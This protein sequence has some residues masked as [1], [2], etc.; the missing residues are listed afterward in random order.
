MAAI[1]VTS[2]LQLLL[3]ARSIT[4]VADGTALSAWPDDSPDGND[5]AQGTAGNRPVYKTNIFG[6]NPAVRTVDS[7]D[8]LHG[9]FASWGAHA[10]MTVLLCASNLPASGAQTA[11]GRFFTTAAAGQTDTANMLLG[12]VAASMQLWVNGSNRLPIALNMASAG[13]TQPV[14]FGGAYSSSVIDMIINGI[15]RGNHSYAGGLPS[16]PT[17]YSMGYINVGTPSTGFSCLADYHFIVVYNRRLTGS[18]LEQV[19]CWMRE[20][21]GMQPA[22]SGG[23]G[24]RM[25][26]IRGG[27]DQ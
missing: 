11:S 8:F 9:S 6:S 14:I 12:D 22:A 4:P 2:G 19:A 20:E 3:D 16:S 15:W 25:V 23:G 24:A 1:P 21:L 18:E 7:G 17:L 13:G 27:A 26:N 5:A 10:G